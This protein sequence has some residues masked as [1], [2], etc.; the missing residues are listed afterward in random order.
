M[1]TKFTDVTLGKGHHDIRIVIHCDGSLLNAE[2]SRSQI[3]VVAIA[4][5]RSQLYEDEPETEYRQPDLPRARSAVKM[6][7]YVRATPIMWQSQRCP[8]VANSTYAAEA[9]SMFLAFDLGCVLRQLY[10][11]LMQGCPKARIPVDIKND[12]LGLVRAIHAIVAQPAEK[13]LAGIINAMR[14]MLSKGEIRTCA[15]IPGAANMADALTKALPGHHLIWLLAE[16]RC[17]AF[18][19]ADISKKRRMAAAGKQYLFNTRC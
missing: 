5:S 9:Q 17:E 15:H 2:G 18:N 6:G 12:N 14:E 16:N 11:E 1:K 10:G 13:R 19:P 3:G 8:R 7:R 4:M